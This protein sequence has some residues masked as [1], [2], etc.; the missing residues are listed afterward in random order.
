M[1]RIAWKSK[2]TDTVGFGEFMFTFKDAV[3]N[4]NNLN[5]KYPDI[6]HWIESNSDEH[7][8][9]EKSKDSNMYIGS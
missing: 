1:Y 8:I 2:L 5:E 9:N 6:H 4:I 3:L 7:L